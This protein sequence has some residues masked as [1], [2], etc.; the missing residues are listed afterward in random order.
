MPE[1]DEDRE[2]D[3]RFTLANERTF[4]SWIRT[5]LAV[6]AA[7]A[8]VA[9]LLPDFGPDALRLI[10][11]L[12]LILLALLLT[13]GGYRRWTQVDRA[14]RAGRPL[15]AHHLPVVLALAVTAAI[16]VTLALVAFG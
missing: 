4:L 8:A 2:P 12:G 16:V 15:P 10:L 9:H 5:A 14:L 7:G 3:Y 13:L 1:R 6:L 11:G